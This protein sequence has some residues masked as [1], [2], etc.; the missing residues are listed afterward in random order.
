[1][2]LLSLINDILDLSK[3]E[4]GKLEL[5]T[6]EVGIRALLESSLVMVKEKALKEN[7]SLSCELDG[8]PESILA[9]QRKLKQILYNLLANAVKFTPAGG[10]IRLSARV[11][12]GL[13]IGIQNSLP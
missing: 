11:V 6:S 9:D 7:L 4:A 2:H 3:I 10:E 5:V 12:K 1:M 13:E 8:I